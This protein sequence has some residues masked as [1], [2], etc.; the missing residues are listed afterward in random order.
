MT[1]LVIITSGLWT[2]GANGVALTSA[3]F[4]STL[5]Y[6]GVIVAISLALFAFTTL[7]G[8][9]Y[10]GER[11]V[12]FLFGIKAIVPYRIVWVL[13]IPIGAITS[14][15]FV[16]LLADALNA[17]MAIPNLIALLILSPAVFAMT[18]NYWPKKE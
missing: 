2:S 15:D 7:L 18:R 12:E 3:A 1:G 9:S 17:M 5:P 11:A 10:Y 13:A 6:G 16:W 8:W 14:L 4:D